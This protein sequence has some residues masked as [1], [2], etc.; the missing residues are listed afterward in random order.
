[1]P[2]S[3][4]TRRRDGATARPAR[5]PTRND[6]RLVGAACRFPLGSALWRGAL[7][8]ARRLQGAQAPL[9]V[10]AGA[11]A[12]LLDWASPWT[13]GAREGKRERGREGW[14]EGGRER[15]RGRE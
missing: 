11:R 12:A 7:I 14:R 6:T 9:W 15:E 10:V 1:M 4:T 8:K 3:A 13:A 5:R 2:D